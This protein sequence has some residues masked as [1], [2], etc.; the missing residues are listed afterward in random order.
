ME[1]DAPK[2]KERKNQQ[3]I[4]TSRKLKQFSAILYSASQIYDT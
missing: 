1:R 4:V 2:Q 3:T